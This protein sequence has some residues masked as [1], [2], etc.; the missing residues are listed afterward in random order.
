MSGEKAGYRWGF[1]VTESDIDGKREVRQQLYQTDN[2]REL[3]KP[4]RTLSFGQS[5]MQWTTCAADKAARVVECIP[6]TDR[7]RSFSD[8]GGDESLSLALAGV[9]ASSF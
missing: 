2:Q 1:E 7:A 5:S 8:V 9:G 6:N 4:W 3:L